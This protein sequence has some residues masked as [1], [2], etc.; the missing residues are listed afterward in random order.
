MAQR[1]LYLHALCQRQR[2]QRLVVCR[3]GE[4]VVEY[5]VESLRRQLL[6]D[7]RLQTLRIGLR[8]VREARVQFLRELHVV[9]AVDTQY[10]FHHVAL[11][12]YIYAVARHSHMP[13]I[14]LLRVNRYLQRLQD[15]LQHLLA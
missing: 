12:L 7:T 13:F 3:L 5:L 11:A 1:I 8:R 6:A 2:L 15:S 4:R 9:V 14:P 10:I